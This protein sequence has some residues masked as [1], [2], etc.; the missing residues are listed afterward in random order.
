M[1]EKR[2]QKKL[3]KIRVRG[4]RQKAKYEMEEKYAEYYPHREGAKVSNVMLAIV[5]AI[6]IVYTVASFILQFCTSVE[7][8]PTLTTCLF[9]FISVELIS[10]AGIRISK[11]KKKNDETPDDDEGGVG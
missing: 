10:L 7:I 4:E 3:E 11:G 2:F 5:V 6:V 9:S 1:T 8:S